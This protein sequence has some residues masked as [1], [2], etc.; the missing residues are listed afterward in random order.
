M[1]RG[2]KCIINAHC[3]AYGIPRRSYCNNALLLDVSKILIENL[4]SLAVRNSFLE[5]TLP[6]RQRAGNVGKRVC[7]QLSGSIDG[8]NKVD[9]C[10][11]SH[12]LCDFVT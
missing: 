1:Q 11:N 7:N 6:V 5:R 2:K 12:V 10:P 8:K 9:A 4:F 3:A